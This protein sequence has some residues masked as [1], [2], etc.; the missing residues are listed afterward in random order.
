MNKELI[1]KFGHHANDTGS[2][3]VQVAS[4]TQRINQLNE[5][6]SR[7]PKDFASKRGI[8]KLVGQRRRFLSYLKETK[9]EAYKKLLK[10][11]NLRK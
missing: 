6:L 5:H 2:A 1:E 9:E 10:E 3:E 4:L 8:L 7:F 11:L